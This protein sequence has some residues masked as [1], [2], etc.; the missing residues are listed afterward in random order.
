[1][2]GARARAETPSSGSLENSPDDRASRVRF[3]FRVI[4]SLSAQALR[5]SLPTWTP[6]NLKWATVLGGCEGVID[7]TLIPPGTQYGA[8]RGKAEKDNGLDMRDLQ[9]RATPSN[10]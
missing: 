3:P 4:A 5:E 2:V 7:T 1:M 9:P 8:T 6:K 10:H